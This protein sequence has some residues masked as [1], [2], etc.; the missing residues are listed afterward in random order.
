MTTEGT[1]KVVVRGD[2]VWRVV[3]DRIGQLHTTSQDT[4]SIFAEVRPVEV[5]PKNG[6]RTETVQREL[7]ELYRQADE[8]LALLKKLVGSKS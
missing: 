1:S 6:N 8:D 2:G 7:P 5:A 4:G 3:S